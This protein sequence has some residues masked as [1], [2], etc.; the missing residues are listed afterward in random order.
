MNQRFISK[1]KMYIRV[2]IEEA[3]RSVQHKIKLTE[4]TRRKENGEEG[5]EDD[6]NDWTFELSYILYKFMY[7]MN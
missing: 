1:I 2:Y 4:K 3:H 7:E 5:T 6:L